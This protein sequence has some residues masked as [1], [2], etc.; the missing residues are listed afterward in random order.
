MNMNCTFDDKKKGKM[1]P[2]GAPY[3]LM[4]K[5][6]GA[7]TS[8]RCKAQGSASYSPYVDRGVPAFP[9]KPLLLP[10]ISLQFFYFKIT[11]VNSK[12]KN[13]NSKGSFNALL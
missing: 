10:L 11:F 12:Y 1:A 7:K 3:P 4:I 2:G 9:C 6:G 8:G 5:Q 13:T